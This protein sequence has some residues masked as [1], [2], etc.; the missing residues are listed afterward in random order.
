MAS[1]QSCSGELVRISDGQMIS[2]A[3]LVEV[4]SQVS[5]VAIGERHG[6][7]AHPQVAACFLAAIS[8]RRK[9]VLAVE[10]ISS[11]EQENVDTYRNNHPEAVDGL[12]KTLR[13]WKSG[14]PVWKTYEPLFRSAWISRA[15]LLG[16]DAPPR[17]SVTVMEIEERLG[18]IDAERVRREWTATMQDAHC[19]RIDINRASRLGDQQVAR[20]MAMA[21]IVNSAEAA[22]TTVLFYAGR[23]HVRR[24]RSVPL[25]LSKIGSSSVISIALHEIKIG[26][27][28]VNWKEV[29]RDAK[30]RY[31]YVWFVGE[32]KNDDICKKL[33]P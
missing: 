15:K 26:N 2:I 16:A 25:Q 24:D 5:V 8:E 4:S 3:E 19:G 23:S 12:G 31:D 28:D 22:E 6:V 10:Q 21:S 11:I 33:K 9:A 32:T 14:W 30:G 7:E 29:L 20:D 1:A 27:K 17:Y 18:I 13:W